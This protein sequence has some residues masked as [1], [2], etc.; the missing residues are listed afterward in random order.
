MKR[1]SNH[2]EPWGEFMDGPVIENPQR[3]DNKEL[4]IGPLYITTVNLLSS[5]YG[6]GRIL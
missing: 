6:K 1:F 2:S 3:Y 5:F 4:L